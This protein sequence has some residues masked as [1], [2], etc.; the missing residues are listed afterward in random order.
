MVGPAWR[1]ELKEELVRQGL[2]PAY[3]ERLVQELCDHLDDV[4]EESMSMEAEKVLSLQN[5]WDNQAIW[6]PRL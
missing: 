6:L 1:E 5:G 4:M 3:I 2:P